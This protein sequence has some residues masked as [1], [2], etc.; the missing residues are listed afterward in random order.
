MKD[1]YDTPKGTKVFLTL[2]VQHHDVSAEKGKGKA[3]SLSS[4]SKQIKKATKDQ[5][6]GGAKGS[7]KGKND[8]VV[9]GKKEG[10]KIVGKR[11]W[12]VR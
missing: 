5:S 1:V 8:K 7:K 9:K 2:P 4:K 11:R 6:K 12:R 10:K 3:A